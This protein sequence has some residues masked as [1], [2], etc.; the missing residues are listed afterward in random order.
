MLQAAAKLKDL[1]TAILH[2]T[3]CSVLLITLKMLHFQYPVWLWRKHL[4]AVTIPRRQRDAAQATS[5]RYW[6]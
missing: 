3:E 2:G 1:L 4:V 5:L 6:I